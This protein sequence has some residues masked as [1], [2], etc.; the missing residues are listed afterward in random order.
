MTNARHLVSKGRLGWNALAGLFFA[1]ALLL[2]EPE[3]SPKQAVGDVPWEDHFV[4]SQV[5]DVR[6][7]DAE[8]QAVD[9]GSM[10]RR[11]PLVI[12][13]VFAS[14]YEIC[15]FYL[16][17]LKKAVESV[18]GAGESYDV[19]VVSFDPRDTPD[20]MAMVAEQHGLR[21]A[22]GWTFAVTSPEEARALAESIGFWID[23]SAWGDSSRLD[24]PAML[25]AIDGG[26]VVRL[27]VGATVTPRRLREV[28]WELDRV[29]VPT[30]PLPSEK[31]IFRCFGF[32]PATGS[33]SLDWGLL[34]LVLP[35]A[36]M[37]LSAVVI[38]RPRSVQEV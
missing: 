6:L 35:A 21:S 11:R 25:A 32:D 34:L 28:V 5:P 1:P 38:F 19:V 36:V 10:W 13:M 12:T 9:L 17:S 2:A 18:G 15:P 24:H 14:C 30:Y 23:P 27:L 29:L 22:P 20:A 33:I 3:P 4:Y 8:G 16:R 31:V 26:V 37:F 7:T